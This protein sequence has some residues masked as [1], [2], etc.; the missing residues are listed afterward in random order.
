MCGITGI[1]NYNNSVLEEELIL[2]L[3]NVIFHRGPDNGSVRLLNNVALG[4]R[5]LSIIDLSENANQPFTSLNGRYTIV[6]N[7]EVYN[8]LDIRDKLILRGYE[9]KTKS[10]TEVILCAYQEYGCSCFDMFNGMFAFAIYDAF[11]GELLLA[12]DQFGIKPLYYINNKNNFVFGSEIKSIKEHSDFTS[13]ISHQG[14][15]EYIW[16]GNPLGNN[17][18]YEDVKELEPGSYMIISNTGIKSKKYFDINTIKQQDISEKDAISEI[19]RL[20]ENSI[21]RHLIS[22]VPVGVFLS[23][24]IDSSAL[25]ALGAKH[26]SGKLKTYSVGFDF[27]GGPNELGL[28]AKLAKQ[29]DTDH[30]E[31]QISG[32]NVVEVIEALVDAHDEPFGDAADI[33]LYLLTQKIKG[34]I[35]VV[36]QGDGG[37]EFFGGYSRYSTLRNSKKWGSLS[38]L[39]QLINLSKTSRPELLRLQRFIA[40]ISEKDPAVRNALLLTMESKFRSPINIFNSEYSKILSSIDP[41]QC[42]KVLYRNL[43]H[44]I[45]DVQAL[46]YSDSQ[47]ILKDTF[48]EKV[49]KSTMANSIEVRVPLVDKELAE[50]MLSIPASLKVKGGVNKYLLKK[51]LDGIVPDEILYG[52]KTGFSVPYAYWLQTS[53]AGYFKEQV[54]TKK[55]GEY[56]NHTE[57]IKMFDLHKKGKGNYGFLLWKTLIFAVWVNKN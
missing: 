22:D 29:Y 51:A 42:Y 19:K 20:L 36:L 23:G 2:S 53:L 10:D 30:H 13:T 7:G 34:D 44:C 14:L 49:D 16:F 48:F 35:K 24:G 8:F 31:I 1:F 11:E 17:T 26:Y 25:V 5:R 3:N 18:I 41:F 50:F 46:F 9:F 32:K 21:K 6:Y 57:V 52:K 55:V 28:A 33:P 40:A 37:D 38:F 45:D 43:P 4:H 15:S 27:A 54:S 39:P 56:I 47:V 12:R